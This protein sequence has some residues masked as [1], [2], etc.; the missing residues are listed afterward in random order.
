LPAVVAVIRSI[1]PDGT[2]VGNQRCGG[3]CGLALLV[4]AW[5]GPAAADSAED[6]AQDQDWELWLGGCT[7]VI[8]SVGISGAD[9]ARAPSLIA[10]WAARM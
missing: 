1:V 7:A 8:E 4:A 2:T 10:L 6:C 5:A 9:L 3:F